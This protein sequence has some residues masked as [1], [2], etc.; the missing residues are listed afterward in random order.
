M[1]T[2]S[3]HAPITLHSGI[4]K[5]RIIAEAHSISESLL[6]EIHAAIRNNGPDGSANAVRE[7]AR[8][9]DSDAHSAN[10]LLH[11]FC[12]NVGWAA[13]AVRHLDGAGVADS[14]GALA[15]FGDIEMDAKEVAAAVTAQDVIHPDAYP[16][17]RFS[18]RDR[19][20]EDDL[21][22]GAGADL[23]LG[24][25][26]VNVSDAIG[27]TNATGEEDNGA[28]GG[29]GLMPAVWAFNEAPRGELAV[30]GS[31]GFVVE[32]ARHTSARAYYERE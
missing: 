20:D 9:A 3:D 28:I 6:E 10:A 1:R 26:V 11:L 13:A 16:F 12:N 30:G 17:K 32:L 4:D 21:L 27:D 22:C 23:G 24:D 29:E 8:A 31:R 19:P 5:T 25:Y 18:V 7:G 2:Q 15:L 14:C